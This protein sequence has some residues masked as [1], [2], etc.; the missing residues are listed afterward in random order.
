MSSF[1]ILMIQNPQK[2]TRRA[3]WA[4]AALAAGAT[5]CARPFQAMAQTTTAHKIADVLPHVIGPATHYDVKVSGDP[6]AI[7]RGRARAV[8]I[9]GTQ[10]QVSSDTTLDT[11]QIDAQDVSFDIPQHRMAHVGR[12]DFTATMSQASLSAYLAQAKIGIP[13]LTVILRQSDVEVKMPVQAYGLRTVV[14]LNGDFVPNAQSTDKVDFVASGVHVG[15][16][17][18]PSALINL[19]L[20]EANP[21]I[22]LSQMK[23]GLA[24]RHITVSNKILQFQGQAYLL[25]PTDTPSPQTK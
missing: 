20:R 5:G 10:V 18:V 9:T 6:T 14:T 19:A 7:S 17:P 2:N 24:L 16:L 25:P 12:A 8:H 11:L 15:L 4:L 1:L 3:L 13:G 22:D 23:V 21:L